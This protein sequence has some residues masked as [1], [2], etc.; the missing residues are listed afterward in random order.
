MTFHTVSNTRNRSRF[1]RASDTSPGK[2]SR[3]NALSRL[4]VSTLSRNQAALAPNFPLGSAA[5][6]QLVL[7]R[8]MDMFH[9]AGLLQM[10]V[11][12][13]EAVAFPGRHDHNVLH[14]A[15]IGKQLA[16]APTDPHGEIT[17]HTEP[18]LPM[19]A[20]VGPLRHFSPFADRLRVGALRLPGALWQ[21]HDLGVQG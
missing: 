13:R 5:G 12:Q 20:V 8:V 9:G 4:S 1:V 7:D 17:P 21:P 6:R 2:A 3:F 10:P 11:D 18:I 15:A 16:L 14:R 19:V